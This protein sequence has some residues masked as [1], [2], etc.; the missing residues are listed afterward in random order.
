MTDFRQQFERSA[1]LSLEKREKLLHLVG[2]HFLQL[3]LD[4]GV[5]RFSERFSFPF[6][7]LGTE[8]ENT[9]TWLWAWAEEQTEMPDHLL[10]ASRD[11]RAW[12]QG[13]G[14]NSLA[15]PSVDL[16]VAD[17]TMIS[18]VAAE[19]SKAGAFYRDHYEGGA[20]FILLYGSEIDAQ[21]DLDRAG[22]LRA[23]TDLASRYGFNHRNAFCSYFL[24]KGLPLSES[25]GTV[26]AQTA[27]GERIVAE[28]GADGRLE[29][30]NGEPFS[31]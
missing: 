30:I 26:N 14:L 29:T 5:A 15:L 1:L 25:A 20:L 8:S 2:E 31:A 11:L 24:A 27:A 12:L 9:L 7:V 22:L 10:R 6:Q 23:F 17:G 3:D 16:D 19:V 21:P 4:A 28:F 18:I 13:A